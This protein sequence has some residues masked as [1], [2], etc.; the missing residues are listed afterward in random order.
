MSQV[1]TKSKLKVFFLEILNAFSYKGWRHLKS[2]IHFVSMVATWILVLMIPVVLLGGL[3][4]KSFHIMQVTSFSHLIFSGNW[5]PMAGQFG[6]AP[7]I[8]G[9]IWVTL[10]SVLFSL[11]VCFFSSIYLVYFANPN[12]LKYFRPVIDILAGIPSVIYGVWGIL[13]IIPF[14]SETVAPFFGYS[15]SGFNILSGALVLSVMII[16]FILNIL[17]EIFKS[18]PLGLIETALSLG[19]TKW[20]CIRDAVVRK[21]RP[22]VISAYG[23]GLSRAFGETIAIMMVVGNIVKIPHG[24]F[25]GA[26]PLPALIANNYGEMLSIPLYDSAL[27]FAAL[28]L[29]VIVTAF[30]LL[31]RALIIKYERNAN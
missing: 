1:F 24:I 4:F 31:S 15:T 17:I 26:Y 28:L 9:S 6:F 5:S 27:M 29:F 23:L 8:L 14:V 19:A 20:Q 13:I 2:R 10:L 3:I 30:N 25:D 11:P 16:P 22:G 18:V 21:A 12:L 7:F